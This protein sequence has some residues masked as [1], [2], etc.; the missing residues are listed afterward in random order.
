MIR[1]IGSLTISYKFVNVGVN[2]YQDKW[3][4]KYP[5]TYTGHQRYQFARFF[6]CVRT[7][8]CCVSSPTI[9]LRESSLNSSQVKIDSIHLWSDSKDV[10]FW[11]RSHPARWHIYVVNYCRDILTLTSEAHWHYVKTKDNPDDVAF[12]SII[13]SLYDGYVREITYL[14]KRS[15]CYIM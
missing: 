15:S 13:S 7:T 6:R 10:F 11:L 8:L 4:L 5:D 3:K 2:N 9:S 14:I 12:R 1:I